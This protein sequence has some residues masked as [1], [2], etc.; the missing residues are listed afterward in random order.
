MS[1]RGSRAGKVT[2]LNRVLHLP[3]FVRVR[4]RRRGHSLM[5]TGRGAITVPARVTTNIKTQITEEVQVQMEGKMNKF[6]LQM[7]LFIRIDRHGYRY[8][9]LSLGLRYHKRSG[10]LVATWHT[11]LLC[12][13]AGLTFPSLHPPPLPLS[14]PPSPLPSSSPSPHSFPPRRNDQREAPDCR[15]FEKIDSPYRVL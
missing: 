14:S 6:I 9:L 13:L 2:W 7:L 4:P 10:G 1:I 3:G 12:K 8:S 5:S 15:I 11:A